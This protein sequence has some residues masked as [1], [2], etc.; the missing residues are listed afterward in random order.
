MTRYLEDGRLRISN[1]HT[2]RAMRPVGIGRKNWLF[3]GSEAGG[4]N[5]A[6]ILSL[7]TTC[8]ALQID[9]NAYLSDVL[10]RVNTHP[11]S[12][13]EELLPDKWKESMESA[14]RKVTREPRPE[15]RKPD[16]FSLPLESVV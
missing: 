2:E 3:V 8:R 10:S 13:L 12:R 16:A 1:I 7:V 9:V 11:M 5:L 6:T 4:E 14:G 15:W